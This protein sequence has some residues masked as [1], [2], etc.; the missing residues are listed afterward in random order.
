MGA[1]ASVGDHVEADLSKP[2]DGREFTCATAAKKELC[3][4]SEKYGKHLDLN[5][6]TDS[7][8]ELD[9]AAAKKEIGRIR[10]TMHDKVR[11]CIRSEDAR[12]T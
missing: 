8:K 12:F 3:S 9:L 6:T 2:K 10:G 1:G 11:Q 4:L 7:V 5:H